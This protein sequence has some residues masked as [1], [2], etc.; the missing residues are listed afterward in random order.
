MSARVTLE[1]TA[2][3]IKGKVFTF[4]RHDTFVFGRSR[5]CHARLSRSDKAASRHHFIMEVNPPYARVRDLG[6]LNGTL[7]NGEKHGGRPRHETPLSV[8]EQPYPEIDINHGDCIQVGYTV[9]RVIVEIPVVCAECGEEVA[10]D[11]R[12]AP[13]DAASPQICARCAKKIKINGGAAGTLP[14][15]RCSLCGKDGAGEPFDPLIGLPLCVECRDKAADNP[16]AGMYAILRDKT[17]R[18]VESE[19]A[20][21][22]GY[23]VVGSLG[24]GAMGA[25]Y[26][27]VRAC[28]E[29][30]VAIKV[31]LAKVAVKEHLRKNFRREMEVAMHLR[32]PNI[33]EIYE[34]GSA[35]RGFYFIMEY[36]S[37]GSVEFLM[38]K[39]GGALSV[40][41]AGPIMLQALKGL[42]YAHQ[43]GFVHRDLKPGNILLTAEADGIAKISDLGSSKNFHE[44]GFSGMTVTGALSGTPM[45][46]PKEQL[47]NFKYVKP[48][49][50]VWGMAAS[51][52]RIL[53]GAYP[54]HLEA[55]ESPV[56]AVL[57]RGAIPIGERNSGIRAEVAAVID[58]ALSDKVHE[59]YQ[60]AGE[61]L[62]ALGSV[63]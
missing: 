23:R 33:V 12:P 4:D 29:K 41:E 26:L 40:D 9:F 1:V 13:P 32:H 58:R 8:G 44:A 59:R 3:P 28:D 49:S 2:G 50:D 7:V 18:G 42:A 37:G 19:Q 16:I 17:G 39:R 25:V 60:N 34:H 20:V 21:F 27:A 52:Y 46:M 57:K 45:Y 48:V 43:E 61:F 62:D 15:P 63:V 11:S 38:E 22:P 51:F 55:G 10:D 54:R 35:G 31:I 5:N 53:T 36:C 6:S 24:K 56:A 30:E 14:G 47:L